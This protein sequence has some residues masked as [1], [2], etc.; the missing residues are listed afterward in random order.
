MLTM[1]IYSWNNRI[2]QT[3]RNFCVWEHHCQ[4]LVSL[5]FS[6]LSLQVTLHPL[7]GSEHQLLPSEH[8]PL[9]H[10]PA[11]VHRDTRQEIRLHL[12]LSTRKILSVSYIYE[13]FIWHVPGYSQLLQLFNSS[14]SRYGEPW[15][16]GTL[17]F[18][19]FGLSVLNYWKKL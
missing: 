9:G 1:L 10:L 4:M 3:W 14:W 17:K 8:R 16:L 2:N 6:H 13:P 18:N 7:T 11:S 12:S 19:L 15:A 5:S